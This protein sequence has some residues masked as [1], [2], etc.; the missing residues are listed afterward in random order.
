MD[1]LVFHTGPAG[2][3]AARVLEGFH[4]ELRKLPGLTANVGVIAGGAEV[5]ALPE[6][7]IT[8]A[9]IAAKRGKTVE[10]IMG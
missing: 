9:E 2:G 1:R 8:P 6:V 10:E 4:A 7:D 5:I 3:E